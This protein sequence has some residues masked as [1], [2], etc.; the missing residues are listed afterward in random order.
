MEPIEQFVKPIFK[1]GREQ[2]IGLSNVFVGFTIVGGITIF[3]YLGEKS[4]LSL[5]DFS[6]I[7]AVTL[8]CL[9]LLLWLRKE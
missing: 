4:S 9:I 8:L 5:F 6:A 2:R 1:L 7:A 3:S